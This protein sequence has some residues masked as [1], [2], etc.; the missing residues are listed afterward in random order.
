MSATTASSEE[1]KG[2]RVHVFLVSQ[3]LIQNSHNISSPGDAALNETHVICS[4][5]QYWWALYKW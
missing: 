2:V 1:G 3:R 5:L 4:F